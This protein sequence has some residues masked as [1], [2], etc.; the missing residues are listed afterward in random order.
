MTWCDDHMTR[1]HCCSSSSSSPISLGGRDG[2]SLRGR[3]YRNPW[4]LIMMSSLT[5][6]RHHQQWLVRRSYLRSVL[7]EELYPRQLWN[8]YI[9]VLQEWKKWAWHFRS[10]AS[11][12]CSTLDEWSP[13]HGVWLCD[14]TEEERKGERVGGREGEKRKWTENDKLYYSSVKSQSLHLLHI[15]HWLC[16]EHNVVVTGFVL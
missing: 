13:G 12:C 15:F 10:H 7:R 4:K 14:S 8:H 1:G 9:I 11:Y 3:G 6:R 16:S 5:Q 2:G